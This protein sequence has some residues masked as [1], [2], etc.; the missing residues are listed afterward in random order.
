MD[1]VFAD[2]LMKKA[3]YV[4]PYEAVDVKWPK[5]LTLLW[6]EQPYYCF[7]ME[8]DRPGSVYVGMN[9]QRVMTSLPRVEEGAE[10]DGGMIA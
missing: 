3:G 5:G 7:L 6:T 9:D 10:D 4:G 1:I 8:G 2:E